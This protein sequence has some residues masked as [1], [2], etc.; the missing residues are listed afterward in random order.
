MQKSRAREARRR[1]RLGGFG[2]GAGLLA[3]GGAGVTVVA[4]L[5]HR[6]AV[7]DDPLWP[8]LSAPLRGA[9][10]AV[11]TTDGLLLHVEVFGPDQ[12]PTVV[13]IPGWT[14]ELQV[15]DLLTRALVES[16]L[17]VVAYD[18]RGQG[19]SSAQS[20]VDQRIE[21][22]GQ[23]LAAVLSACCGAR[24]DVVVAGHSMGAM[25]LV[26]W[27]ESTLAGAHVR[28]AALISTGVSGLIEAAGVLPAILPGP[29]RRALLAALATGE[30]PALPVSTPVSRAVSRHA[31][32]GPDASAAQLAF[33]EPMVWRMPAALRAGAARTMRDLD[34]RAALARLDVPTLVV[35][36]ECDRLT[37]PEH[38]ERIAGALPNLAEL[39]ILERTGHMTPLERPADLAAALL[40]LMARVGLDPERQ[41]AAT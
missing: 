10:R 37:P 22:Y 29:A 34:L 13:L 3:A 35:A 15:F 17:R 39:V 5:R 38:A 12:A 28:A 24:D 8:L 40:R 31:L 18:P 9:P 20:V 27:A 41:R 26:A 4:E 30:Q 6:Q 16:G 25:A 14:E 1:G 36:G 2:I 33:I 21:R 23:D 7:S 32:F 11:R 19:A